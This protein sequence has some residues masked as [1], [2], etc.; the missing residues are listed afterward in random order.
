M[1]IS[2][3]YSIQCPSSLTWV[4]RLKLE[5]D[6]E[7]RGVQVTCTG[8]L[9]THLSGR[10]RRLKITCLG[11]QSMTFVPATLHEI[12]GSSG[13]FSHFTPATVV[14]VQQPFSEA[15][16]CSGPWIGD[17]GPV[18]L[19]APGRSHHEGVSS[20]QGPP[21]PSLPSGDAPSHFLRRRGLAALREMEALRISRINGRR[22]L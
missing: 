22:Y 6:P 10:F 13:P 17:S 20:H 8:L 12:G 11:L 9:D 19:L 15:Q 3:C 14:F 7:N 18:A 2:D 21:G 4:I 1:L 16:L 5:C